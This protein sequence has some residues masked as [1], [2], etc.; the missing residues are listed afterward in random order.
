LPSHQ[1]LTTV[2]TILLVLLS[3]RVVLM[4]LQQEGYQ[5]M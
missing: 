4:K 1:L 3:F 5:R 2:Y